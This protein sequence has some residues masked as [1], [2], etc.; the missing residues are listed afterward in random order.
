MELVMEDGT[1]YRVRS[2]FGAEQPTGEVLDKLFLEKIQSGKLNPVIVAL[3]T[4]TSYLVIGN[5]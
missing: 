5:F 1:V 3:E 2:F 4:G